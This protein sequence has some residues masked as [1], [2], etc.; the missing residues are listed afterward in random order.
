M[1]ACVVRGNGNSRTRRGGGKGKACDAAFQPSQ[2]DGT[3]V[4]GRG[5]VWGGGARDA[6]KLKK[7]RGRKPRCC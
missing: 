2:I 3:V 6:V 7:K 1:G 5:R 4:E